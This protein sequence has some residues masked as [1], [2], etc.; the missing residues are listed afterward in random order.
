MNSVTNSV[1]A[2]DPQILVRQLNATFPGIGA[3]LVDHELAQQ[4]GVCVHGL[5]MMPDGLPVFSDLF[6]DQLEY[7]GTLHT[8]F[9]AWLEMRGWYVEPYDGDRLD[10]VRIA[11]ADGCMQGWAE[12]WA[13]APRAPVDFSNPEMELPF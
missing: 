4:P 7:D 8:G 11:D 9:E 1:E 13:A 12:A 10:L 5:A 3:R 2:L 6:A